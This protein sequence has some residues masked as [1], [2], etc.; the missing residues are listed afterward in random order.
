MSQ[1]QKRIISGIS[2]L[3]CLSWAN[4][5]LGF[6][7]I[8][9]LARLL[10][11]ADFGIMAIIM[12]ALQ[13]TDTL[14]NIGSE[15]YFIQKKN[16]NKQDLNN[17][18]SCNLLF[19][20]FTSIIF[21]IVAPIIAAYFNSSHLIPAFLI[22]AFLPTI[23]ALS[24]GWLMQYKKDMSYQKIAHIS[25]SSRFLGNVLTILLAIVF[26]NYWALICGAVI[27]ALLYSVFS[28]TFIQSKIKF[29]IHDWKEHLHFSK[30]VIGKGFIGHIRA[31][32]DN[33]FA[34]SIQGITGLG[35][36]NFSKDLVLMPSRELLSPIAEVF[37][38]SIAKTENS[39]HEQHLKIRKSFAII[40]LIAFPIS[41]GWSLIAN[42][43]VQVI[44]GEQ[45]VP[46][47][48]LISILG[49]SLFTYGLG[50]FISQIM[51][52]TNNVKSLFYYDLFT[53][54]FSLL[55][56]ITCLSIIDTIET[57]AKIKV[58]IDIGIITIGFTW[59]TYLRIGSFIQLIQSSIYPLLAAFVTMELVRL[60]PLG[61]LAPLAALAITIT[62]AGI[63][64]SILALLGCRLNL[65]GVIESK[66]IYQLVTNRLPFLDNKKN[67]N[68]AP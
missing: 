47:I 8:F 67:I 27:S 50:N 28:Y 17:A 64:Y 40:S 5:I 30:W 32:F 29:E 60:M 9:I 13:L 63:I 36:Y 14:T 46:Y 41:F 21:V 43:F 66:F 20:F 4:R 24:N 18:W 38:T 7:S 53:L 31:K 33:W 12:L 57:L 16:T 51:T 26:H 2:W 23:N 42:N 68:D 58:F 25:I 6:C 59:L 65:L 34:A 39:S 62:S 48:S 55:A 35:A 10:S 52:A 56:F 15:Q 1:E 19:K 3:V 54:G 22:I 49:F 11:P 44:L 61:T 37:Y 45:W